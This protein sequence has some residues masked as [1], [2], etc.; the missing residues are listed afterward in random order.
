[1][2]L[3]CCIFKKTVQT[4][5]LPVYAL[6]NTIKKR[7]IRTKVRKLLSGMDISDTDHV[8]LFD[9]LDADGS[10]NLSVSEIVQGLVQVQAPARALDIVRLGG[11]RLGV[12]K[13]R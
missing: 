2:S 12:S 9:V 13:I 7:V 3:T 11:G 1:M 4:N 10:G 6:I 5:R 8:L